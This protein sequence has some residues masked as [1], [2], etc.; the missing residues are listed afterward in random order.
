MRWKVRFWSVYVFLTNIF[1]SKIRALFFLLI[2]SA[3]DEKKIR[4]RLTKIP[5]AVELS[6]KTAVISTKTRPP[7]KQIIILLESRRLSAE[8]KY[9]IPILSVK[10]SGQIRFLWIRQPTSSNLTAKFTF[11][12]ILFLVRDTYHLRMTCHDTKDNAT[13]YYRFIPDSK[14]ITII[15]VSFLFCTSSITGITIL[16]YVLASQTKQ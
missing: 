6:G 11:C 1:G 7:Q 16:S 12:V 15:V 2:I 14:T 4:L 3:Q 5:W 13:L 9:F 8:R 10:C